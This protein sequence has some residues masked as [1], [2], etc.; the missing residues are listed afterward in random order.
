[1]QMCFYF[2]SWDYQPLVSGLARGRG[3]RIR[4]GPAPRLSE[5]PERDTVE[6]LCAAEVITCRLHRRVYSSRPGKETWP[7]WSGNDR[8]E[9]RYREMPEVIQHEDIRN[10]IWQFC[11]NSMHS[12]LQH[13][14]HGAP[15]VR[16]VRGSHVSPC[17]LSFSFSFRYGCGDDHNHCCSVCT[18]PLPSQRNHKMS[19]FC[20]WS[21][22][23][24]HSVSILAVILHRGLSDKV[25]L[26]EPP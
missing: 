5:I 16:M 22:P 12:M 18:L 10:I 15:R 17:P 25:F 13:R 7:I 8:N 4:P 9:M 24:W 20:C 2:F 1:M 14:P 21:A 26:K 11:V 19:W 23:L 3:C 6:I